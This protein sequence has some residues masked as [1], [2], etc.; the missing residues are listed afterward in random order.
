[1]IQMPGSIEQGEFT[2]VL[3]L[4]LNIFKELAEKCKDLVRGYK[5]ASDMFLTE[6][7]HFDAIFLIF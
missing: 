3:K 1:M 5:N 7:L 6:I 2:S 4:C